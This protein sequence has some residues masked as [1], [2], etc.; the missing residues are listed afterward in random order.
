S[1]TQSARGVAVL[2]RRARERTRSFRSADLV[3]PARE[4]R[5]SRSGTD[6]NLRYEPSLA[7]A[8]PGSQEPTRLEAAHRVDPRSVWVRRDH[9]RFSGEFAVKVVRKLAKFK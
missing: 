8:F 2:A 7:A 6:P 9:I 1:N 3:V 5:G 4:C